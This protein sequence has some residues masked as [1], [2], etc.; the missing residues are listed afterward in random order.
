MSRRGAAW[1]V[2]A[3]LLIPLLLLSAAAVGAGASTERAQLEGKGA[4]LLG[5]QFRIS[6]SGAVRREIR[7]QVAWNATDTEYLVVWEDWRGSGW[8]SARGKDLYGR[9]VDANGARLGNNFRISRAVDTW[10]DEAPAVA[11]NATDNEYLV[12][13]ERAADIWAPGRTYEIYG[14]RIKGDGTFTGP[15]FQISGLHEQG[16]PMDPQ[17]AWNSVHDQYLVIWDDGS[18]LGQRVNGDGTLLGTE[19]LV[20]GADYQTTDPTRPVLVFNATREEYL[21]V[22]EDSRG[23][24]ATRGDDIYGRRIA[25]NGTLV[26]GE[27]RISGPGA[28]WGDHYPAAVW[29]GSNDQYLV[30]WE[31]Q[32]NYSEW[33][34]CCLDIYG[35]ILEGDGSRTGGDFRVVPTINTL[36]DASPEVAWNAA[37]NEYLVVYM[38]WSFD[39]IHGWDIW[40]QR[41]TAT[42]AKSGRNFRIIGPKG[43]EEA[44][45]TDDT[46]PALAWNSADNQYLVIWVDF[47][48]E[49]LDFDLEIYG[50][51]V[52]G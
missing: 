29:N 34:Y 10:D 32:R 42:G 22:W 21:A 41:F 43:S 7:P 20:A 3:F 13:W 45:L 30:A 17:V 26:A 23:P 47:R 31:D 51:R 1:R 25:A 24:A 18:I 40:G 46:A 9:F 37:D 16:G 28:T 44:D 2:P 27:F 4:N 12:V 11:W 39:W 52:S 33:D 36:D 14:R 50:R 8:G 38:D 35:T 48:K 5:P 49:D 15:A 19:F 6:G